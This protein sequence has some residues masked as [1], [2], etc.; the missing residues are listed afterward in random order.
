[1]FEDQDFPAPNSLPRF[2]PEAA[3]LRDYLQG[4]SH[5]ELK[6]LCQCNDAITELNYRRYQGM[7]LRR[8][9]SAALL[10]YDGIQYKYMAPQ[11]FSHE[12]WQYVAERLAIISGFYGL[13]RPLDG[14]TPYRLEMQAPLKTAFCRNLYD[15]WGSKI[16]DALVESDRVILNLASEEYAKAVRPYLTPQD[17]FITCIFGVREGD[18]VREKGVY[19]KMARGRMARFLAENQVQSPA[20]C[21]DFQDLGYAY[22]PEL[23]TA[24]KYVFL[25]E[26]G[27][28]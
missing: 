12:E 26:D 10:S 6:G 15:F 24:T 25:Q 17:T 16:Y 5:R 23:S 1:M 9:L 13:L 3:R 2:L 11:V 22:N 14:I 8:G 4:L 20:G 18:K 28:K 21:Q 7:D 19:V 27:V